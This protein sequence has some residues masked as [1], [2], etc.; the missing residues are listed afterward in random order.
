MTVSLVTDLIAV[1][2]LAVVGLL[3]YGA[4][5][6]GRRGESTQVAKVSMAREVLWTA[7]AA[8]LLLGLFLYAHA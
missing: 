7:V 5:S 3:G 8:L 4:Y 2:F 1:L 6:F